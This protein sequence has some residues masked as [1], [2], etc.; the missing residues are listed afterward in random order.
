MVSDDGDS[1][2]HTSLGA[3]RVDL[4]TLRATPDNDVERVIADCVFYRIYDHT[5]AAKVL[6]SLPAG[7]RALYLT[8]VADG[9]VRNGGFNRYYFNT[10]GEFASET[11]EAFEFFRAAR[12]AAV[13]R[14]ANAVRAEEE[15]EMQKF[16]QQFVASGDVEAYSESCEVT[17]LDPI[18]ECYVGLHEDLAQLRIA[19][20]RK[21]PELFALP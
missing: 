18:T 3:T 15:P 4:A 10:D 7:A 21:S 11:V 2:E 12:H 17:K 8:W 19:C 20:I 5:R 9:E 13:M 14:E 1:S 16:K 6:A